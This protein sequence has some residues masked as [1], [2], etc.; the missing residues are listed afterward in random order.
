MKII[1]KNP[2]KNHNVSS[3]SDSSL[4]FRYIWFFVFIAVSLYLIFFI[5]SYVV[6]H[7]ISI[8]DEQRIF[9]FESDVF[10]WV[11]LSETLAERYSDVPYNITRIDMDGEQNAFAS[12]GGNI[13]ITNTLLDSIESYEALDFIVGHEIAHIENRD[14]LKGIISK[15]PITL[16]LSLFWWDYGSLLF[17]GVVWNTHGKI[18]ETKADRYALDFVYEKN[19]HVGCAVD[20]FHE[21]NTLEDNL[22][23]IFSTHPMTGLRIS[24]AQNYINTM[25]YQSQEC[26]PL[27]L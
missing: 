18:T 8:E 5:F 16:L 24:R 14:V 4:F 23:E 12:L 3:E 19:G 26:T 22:M 15:F 20:F 13:Y 9:N 11:A 27:T 21:H 10:S 1:P 25:W 17:N 6:V 2:S 7:F